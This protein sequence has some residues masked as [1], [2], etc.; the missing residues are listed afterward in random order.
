M[1]N[2]FRSKYPGR[3]AIL[4]SVLLFVLWISFFFFFINIQPYAVSQSADLSRAKVTGTFSTAQQFN[5]FLFGYFD[6]YAFLR[7]FVLLH[8]T[9]K[10]IC[11]N[12]QIFF[13]SY[14]ISHRC[15]ADHSRRFL[16]LQHWWFRRPGV[17]NLRLFRCRVA[18]LQFQYAKN[19]IKNISR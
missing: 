4:L 3:H 7:T 9:R 11:E 2:H 17:G 14:K 8:E 16:S 12:F 10:S 19:N 6:R 5:N 1:Y 13:F 15:T 18:V